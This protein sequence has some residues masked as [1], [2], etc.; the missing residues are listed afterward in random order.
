[1]QKLFGTLLQMLAFIWLYGVIVNFYQ[2]DYDKWYGIPLVTT[3]LVFF[4]LLFA[5]IGI[6]FHEAVDKKD[7]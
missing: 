7:C 3:F 4:S 2:L 5:N 1:M 6:A